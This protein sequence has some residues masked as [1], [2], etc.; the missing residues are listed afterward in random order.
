[1]P[2]GRLFFPRYRNVGVRHHPSTVVNLRDVVSR[3]KQRSAVVM[4]GPDAG[5]PAGG[6]AG[7]GAETPSAHVRRFRRGAA[8]TP[9]S[10]SL[11]VV[12]HACERAAN[13][14]Y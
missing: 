1:M 10:C 5:P 4:A 12:S 2:L 9:Q 13:E 11:A 8:S 14:G 6:L 3:R 7:T